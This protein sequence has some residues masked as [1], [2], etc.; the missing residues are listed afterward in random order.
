MLLAAEASVRRPRVRRRYKTA[1]RCTYSERGG[2]ARLL[3]PLQVGSKS[4]SHACPSANP[5]W[6]WSEGWVSGRR[7]DEAE[8]FTTMRTGAS[9]GSASWFLAQRGLNRVTRRPGPRARLGFSRGRCRS[10]KAR[11]G[12]EP[13]GLLWLDVPCI[14]GEAMVLVCRGSVLQTGV[15]RV[16]GE[17]PS[18]V[19]EDGRAGQMAPLH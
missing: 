1:R 17:E 15:C 6:C 2:G 7:E 11:K 14:S 13:G 12:R 5:I 4:D 9:S 16:A 18:W 19:E 3:A 10:G 8:G